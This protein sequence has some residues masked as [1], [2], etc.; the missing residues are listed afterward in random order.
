MFHMAHIGHIKEGNLA[1]KPT[2]WFNSLW[3]WHI[4]IWYSGSTGISGH[5]NRTDVMCL[6]IQ[7]FIMSREV[8][9]KRNKDALRNIGKDQGSH[10]GWF[11]FAALEEH[12]K[13][14]K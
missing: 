7:A 4:S 2:T 9:S 14:G 13:N 6:K 5:L 8:K 11:C 3:P 1:T 12:P 10:C